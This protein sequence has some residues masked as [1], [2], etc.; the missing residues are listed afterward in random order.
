M[1]FQSANRYTNRANKAASVSSNNP[2]PDQRQSSVYLLGFK[3]VRSYIAC[4]RRLSSSG[5][6][7]PGK[8]KR[9]HVNDGTA[10]QAC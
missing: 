10:G 1:T 4:A 7:F 6:H 5:Y 3:P 9:R 8:D 2:L